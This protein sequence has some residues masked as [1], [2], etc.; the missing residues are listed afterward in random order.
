M[1]NIVYVAGFVVYALGMVQLGYVSEVSAA[2]APTVVAPNSLC[3]A[4]SRGDLSMVQALIASGA[5]VNGDS[6]SMRPLMMAAERGRKET[7]ELLL[8][9][10]AD[11]NAQNACGQSALLI[12][13]ARGYLEIVKILV[14]KGNAK[15]DI[16]NCWGITPLMEAA[17]HDDSEMIDYLVEK[18]ANVK[19]KDNKGEMPIDYYDRG[20][21]EERAR[22]RFIRSYG[23]EVDEINWP[24]NIVPVSPE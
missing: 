3:D 17:Y 19:E 8:D 12:A 5:N 24:E 16:K 22:K 23:L 9:K 18:G 14:D 11:A 1:K 20:R 10:G 4:A 2:V 6:E 7:V 15:V 13:A 21:E